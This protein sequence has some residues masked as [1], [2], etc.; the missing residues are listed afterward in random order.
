MNIKANTQKHIPELIT[1]LEPNEKCG[2]GWQ[3]RQVIDGV[4]GVPLDYE[5]FTLGEVT[6]LIADALDTINKE[7]GYNYKVHEV[8][9]ITQE[10]LDANKATDFTAARVLKDMADGTHVLTRPHE[11]DM[12]WQEVDGKREPCFTG[13]GVVLMAYFSWVDDNLPKAAEAVRRYC[14]YLALHGYGKGA[15]AIWED[16]G[17][18]SKDD[19]AEWIRNTYAQ[20]VKDA[21]TLVDMMMSL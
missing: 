9:R 2:R 4:S 14:Q 10:G 8:V 18:M 6:G 15:S 20:Y 19:G 5:P 7:T 21:R 11:V 13:R 16:V 12:E 17:A 3:A 1:Y